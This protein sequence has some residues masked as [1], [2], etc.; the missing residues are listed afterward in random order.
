MSRNARRVIWV[1]CGLWLIAAIGV[2]GWMANQISSNK[3]DAFRD[4]NSLYDSI[5]V[6]GVVI[7]CLILGATAVTSARR[8]RVTVIV[9]GGCLLTT[10]ILGYFGF[11]HLS[12]ETLGPV[13]AVTQRKPDAEKTVLGYHYA[14]P[15]LGG[16][17]AFGDGAVR[18]V[19]PVSF[20]TLRHADLP[21]Q[22]PEFISPAKVPPAKQPTEHA[23]EQ[24]EQ[25][26]SD[27]VQAVQERINHANNLK[28][29]AK[30]HFYFQARDGIRVP[31][32]PEHL[33]TYP[34]MNDELRTAISDGTY[35]WYFGWEPRVS[36]AAEK[37]R[38]LWYDFASWVCVYIA[39][40]GAGSLLAGLLLVIR[41]SDKAQVT[42]NGP[43]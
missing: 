31:L 34:G 21:D 20:S 7:S 22:T 10:G 2:V 11:R 1:A 15:T 13:P 12:A 38:A 43:D 30:G 4:W 18:R 35:V 25:N 19:D 27:R 14:C 16:Y 37:H 23:D 40:F 41:R 28:K 39:G 5:S 26:A 3:V 29:M 24:Q 42:G 33:T 17:V 9:L 6:G 8:T 36:Y 32:K